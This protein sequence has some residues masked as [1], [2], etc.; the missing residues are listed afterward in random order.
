MQEKSKLIVMFYILVTITSVSHMILYVHLV[1]V[2]NA[3]PFIYAEKGIELYEFMELIGS[4]SML[5]LGWLVTATMFQLTVS[6]RVIFNLVTKERS[7]KY[8]IAVYI[9]AAAMATFELLFIM[10]LPVLIDD[11]DKRSSWISYIF[12]MS[13]ATL[14]VSYVIIIT[15]LGYTLKRMKDFGDF[16]Q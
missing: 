5:A 10:L 16:T 4:T 9:Y 7:D 13:Y 6:I 14:T 11:F 3:D 1:I 12:I 2:P 15:F 8:K